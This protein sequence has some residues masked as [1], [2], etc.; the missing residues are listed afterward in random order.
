MRTGIVMVQDDAEFV[1]N[2]RQI[3]VRVPITINDSYGRL[4]LCFEVVAI[5][6]CFITCCYVSHQIRRP[7]LESGKLGI[8]PSDVVRVLNLSPVVWDPLASRY[9]RSRGRAAAR[10]FD[11]VPSLFTQNLMRLQK[12]REAIWRREPVTRRRSRGADAGARSRL[13]LF[14]Y[15]WA[16]FFG[17][18][19]CKKSSRRKIPGHVT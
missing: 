7:F 17:L 15:F 4:L 13:N 8:A 6:P 5:H 19:K 10:G 3:N 11:L 9:N 18:R 14:A 1:N 12:P 16:F 2:F